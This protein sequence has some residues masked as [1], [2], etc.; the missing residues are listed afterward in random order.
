MIQ[1]NLVDNVFRSWM[2]IIPFFHNAYPAM[3]VK[4]KLP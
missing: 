2:S 4:D 3:F 1:L